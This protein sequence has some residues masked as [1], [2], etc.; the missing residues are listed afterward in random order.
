MQHISSHQRPREIIR[1]GWWRRI[2]ALEWGINYLHS[3]R[4][5]FIA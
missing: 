1:R 4:T 3:G 2:S 5:K